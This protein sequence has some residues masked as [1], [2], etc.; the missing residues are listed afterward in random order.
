MTEPGLP[1]GQHTVRQHNLRLVLAELAAGPGSKAELAQ[2]TGLTKATVANLVDSLI[3]QGILHEGDPEG[4]GPGRPSRSLSFHPDGPVAL[5]VEINVDYTSVLALDLTSQVL[6]NEVASVDNRVGRA[7]QILRHA[8]RMARKI[9]RDLDRPALGVTLALPAVVSPDGDVLR[10]PNLPALNGEPARTLFGKALGLGPDVPVAV[11]NEANLGALARLRLA[12]EQGQNFV[13]VSAEVGI[14]AGLVVNGS[15]F[16]GTRGFA[17]ELGHVVVDR[18]GPECGCGGR[19]CVEQYAG[20]EVLLRASQQPDLDSLQRAI[21]AGDQ[22]A[23]AALTEAGSALGV[24]LA[25]LLNVFDLPVVVLGGVYAR[26][27]DQL[28]APLQAELTR[29]V[30]SSR[31]GGGQLRRSALGADAAVRGAASMV[32]DRALQ[33]PAL[34]VGTARR[35]SGQDAS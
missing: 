8:S 33:D 9:L 30:L 35:A 26:L 21:Q 14:G 11:E 15:L 24:G 19:G 6:A 17:G 32:I 29:R 2:R 5:G 13:Y 18:N 16:R 20:L 4:S 34:I 27:F 28:A 23:A 25:S 12:P 10:A 31:Q 1:A 3:P 22:R 7:E